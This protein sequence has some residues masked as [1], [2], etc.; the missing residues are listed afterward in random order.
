[1]T[2]EG[3]MKMESGSLDA[4][5]AS[6]MIPHHQTAVDMAELLL[7]HGHVYYGGNAWTELLVLGR[8]RP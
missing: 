7:R 5:F 6:M 4:M 1:M 2:E 3:G 8:E